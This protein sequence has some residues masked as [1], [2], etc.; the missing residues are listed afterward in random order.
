LTVRRVPI[1]GLTLISLP[2]KTDYIEGEA[3]DLT[4]LA[5]KIS[6]T[7]GRPDEIRTAG[8]ILNDTS[9]I[10]LGCHSE[11]QGKAVVFGE[12]TLNLYYKYPDINCSFTLSA[13]RKALIS[14][15][16]LTEPDSL[17]TYS[18]TEVPGLEG[19]TLSAVYDNGEIVIVYPKDCTVACDPS[20]FVLGSGNKVTVS[21]GGK[22]VELSF[23]YAIDEPTGLK[24]V[25]PKVLN[26]ILGEKID[27]S[28]MKVYLTRKSGAETPITYY[29][30]RGIDPTVSGAQ[31]AQVI[32]GEYSAV[33]NI[34]IS[35][36]YQRGDVDGNGT[37]TAADARLALRSA[38]KLITLGGNPFKAADADAD[39]NVTAADARLVLR[40]AVGLESLLNFDG[41]LILPE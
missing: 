16:V 9:F 31:T 24:I 36:Y 4:G 23:T 32:Y 17:V 37:V 1:K 15:S 40:A 5:V 38:V 11:A 8:E 20:K 13:R 26:F 19:L 30:F 7:D 33:F 6:Y 35:P 29:S 28:S 25:T 41:I 34:N 27:L 21:Y 14:L 39:G 12:H 18:N 3:L 22:S 10:L 2:D